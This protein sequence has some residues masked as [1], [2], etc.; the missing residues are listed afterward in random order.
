[1]LEDVGCTVPGPRCQHPSQQDKV[2]PLLHRPSLPR[3]Q[4]PSGL[5][6]IL[7]PSLKISKHVLIESQNPVRHGCL[8]SAV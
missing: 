7:F 1:M 8:L 4:P 6:Q 2:P 5:D 3:S